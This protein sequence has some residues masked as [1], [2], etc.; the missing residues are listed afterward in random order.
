MA[1]GRGTEF[2]GAVI[3]LFHLL[4][5]RSDKIRALREAFYR[6]N[7]PNLLNLSATILVFAVVIYFQVSEALWPVVC[8]QAHM[9]FAGLQS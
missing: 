5:T 3:A 4:A 7:L 9:Y 8:G 2:E 1:I 6:H